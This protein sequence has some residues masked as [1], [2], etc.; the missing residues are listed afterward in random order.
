MDL[1]KHILLNDPRPIDFAILPNSQF[2]NWNMKKYLK[3]YKN[4][5]ACKDNFNYNSEWNNEFLTVSEIKN[6]LKSN[7]SDIQLY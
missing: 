3:F 2:I 5:K 1:A 6:L 4:G 7:I